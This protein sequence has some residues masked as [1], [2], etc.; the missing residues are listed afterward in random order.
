MQSSFFLQNASLKPLIA[1]QYVM[2]NCCFS[3]QTGH[4]NL[5]GLLNLTVLLKIEFFTDFGGF[6]LSTSLFD[7]PQNSTWILKVTFSSLLLQSGCKLKVMFR[8][9]H[10]LFFVFGHFWP[11]RYEN[12]KILHNLCLQR[13]DGWDGQDG[14]N[15]ERKS[16]NYSY[17]NT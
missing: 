13:Q 14:K 8:S 3:F 6:Q 12:M 5:F 16:H 9:S 10:F 4:K 17:Q 1:T 7:F 2:W 15:P 11:R